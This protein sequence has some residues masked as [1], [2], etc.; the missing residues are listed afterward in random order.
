MICG[1]CNGSGEGRRQGTMCL[2]CRGSG[3]VYV[4]PAEEADEFV[5]PYDI[6]YLAMDADCTWYGYRT[7][8]VRLN[9]CWT[10][11]ED[12]SEPVEIPDGVLSPADSWTES[13]MDMEGK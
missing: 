11:A 6:R 13:L 3:D 1:N 10:H 7:R 12:P 9:T 8:P 4:E 2:S 5:M